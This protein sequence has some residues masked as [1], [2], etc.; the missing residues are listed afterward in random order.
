MGR[1][2]KGVCVRR[3][4]VGCDEEYDSVRIIAD[5]SQA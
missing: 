4:R 3:M 2:G 1:A 5:H